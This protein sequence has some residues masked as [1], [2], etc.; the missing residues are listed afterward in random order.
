M[1]DYNDPFVQLAHNV[2]NDIIS[3]MRLMTL[4]QKTLKEISINT[5]ESI[6]K[7]VPVQ[8]TLK[9]AFVRCS[10]LVEILQ[11]LMDKARS[12]IKNKGE[13]VQ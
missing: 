13:I 3:T 6:G 4:A 2:R 9:E 8:K 10:D 5:P 12:D 11:T 7:L 1:E